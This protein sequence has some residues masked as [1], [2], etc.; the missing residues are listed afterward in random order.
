ME[1]RPVKGSLRESESNAGNLS[2]AAP[3]CRLS[4][5]DATLEEE[6]Y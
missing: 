1:Q 4:T 3:A 5:P 6:T 2:R